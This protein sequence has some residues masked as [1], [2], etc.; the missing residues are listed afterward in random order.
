MRTI[1]TQTK[2]DRRQFLA[3][4]LFP[5]LAR[6]AED[7]FG[8]WT[9]Q[10]GPESAFYRRDGE[11]VIHEGSGFPAWLRSGKQF[12][13]FDFRCEFH[14]QGWSD[15]GIYIH[16]PEHGR[17][18]WCGMQIKLFHQVDKEPT[19]QSMGSV[20]PL[21][22]PLRVNVK[23]RSWNTLRIYMDWPA[24]RV[25]VN[26]EVVQ[27]LNVERTA[28]LRYRLRRGYLG[29][30][31]LSYPLRFRNLQIRELPSREKWETLYEG[32]EDLEAKWY[33]S[34]GEPGFQALGPVLRGDGLGHI[35][36]RAVYKDL[37]LQCY[38]RAARYHNGGVLFRTDG[39]GLK[40]RHYEIQ[41]H[42]VEES[43]F[44]TGSLYYYK[45]ATYPRIED[46]KWYLFQL[47]VQGR[48]ALVRINGENVME[49]EALD[50]LEEGHV[51]LQAHR[52]GYWTEFQHLR[53]KKL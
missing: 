2:W 35:A 50:N 31:S 4:C 6:G 46:E 40:A 52:K 16:A 3:G 8:G 23:D 7:P 9:V 41:L 24:L 27:D 39:K 34:E 15:S 32:P 26:D 25:W 51:E 1:V 43:H 19:P 13:N 11:I 45:R 29:I 38:I 12:E 37:E 20:F 14:I 5:A 30:L 17:P 10:D 48:R 42:N 28:D 49:Y 53:I 47:W 22:A 33:V 44:P 21:V 36:T 18:T